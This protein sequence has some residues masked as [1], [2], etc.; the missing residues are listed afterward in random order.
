MKRIAPFIPMVVAAVSLSGV[1]VASP[2]A[3]E[4]RFILVS[5]LSLS[6]CWLVVPVLSRRSLA[7]GY[8]GLLVPVALLVIALF[9]DAEH[10]L[11][12]GMQVERSSA[13][14]SK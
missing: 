12:Q 2:G 13:S 11:P 1:V 10:S 6:C 5:F 7:L 8:L 4:S 9:L 14:P 3:V